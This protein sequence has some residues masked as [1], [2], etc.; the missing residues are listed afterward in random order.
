MAAQALVASVQ[1]RDGPTAAVNVR[2]QPTSKTSGQGVDSV[3]HQE[4]FHC[5]LPRPTWLMS[6]SLGRSLA[7]GPFSLGKTPPEDAV[8]SLLDANAPRVKRG[9]AVPVRRRRPLRCRSLGEGSSSAFNRCRRKARA[10]GTARYGGGGV[11][12]SRN[13]NPTI[14]SAVAA[15][16]RAA[17]RYLGVLGICFVGAASGLSSV[18]RT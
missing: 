11:R 9:T 8:A 10:W 16:T 2:M 17:Q 1:G 6:T 13:C 15:S 4:R 5:S 14:A 7:G 18:G 12:R 3:T